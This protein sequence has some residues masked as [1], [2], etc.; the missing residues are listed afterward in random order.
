MKAYASGKRWTLYQGDALRWLTEWDGERWDAVIV[1][2][3]YSSGGAF[4]GDR[5]KDPRAKYAN[6][7]SKQTE[8]YESFTGDNRDTRSFALWAGLWLE[9]ARARAAS[10]APLVCFCDWRQL[11]VTADAI[12]VGGW[13]WRGVCPWVKPGARPQMGRF[14]AAAE[15]AVWGTN[16]PAQDLEEVGCLPG[17]VVR[18]S[19]VNE[20][21]HLT[22]KPDEVMC[23][24]VDICRPGGLVLDCFAGSGSTGVAALR[25]GRRFIGVEMSDA[26]CA[27]AAMRLAQAEA[28][29]AQVALFG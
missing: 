2:P 11:P 3:P 21:A 6:S 22:Q 10:G 27:T 1:D 17:Y 24:L 20:R 28:D 15:Y 14:A 7:D 5:N 26:H 18:S 19:V 8:A 12:Q 9:A 13:V 16:G 29:G 4:R 23:W 25:S